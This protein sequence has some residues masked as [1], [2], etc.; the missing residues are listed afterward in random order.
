MSVPHPALAAPNPASP[1]VEELCKLIK[2]GD[3]SKKA[4]EIIEEIKEEGQSIDSICSHS[5]D[6]YTP[7]MRAIYYGRVGIV[8]A[9]ITAGA[10][11]NKFHG[12]FNG[13]KNPLFVAVMNHSGN[14]KITH[15]IIRLLLDKGALTEVKRATGDTPLFDAIKG[16]NLPIVNIL[17]A[18][19]AD[20]NAK[21]N[22]GKTPL[23]L[24][25]ERGRTLIVNAL[26]AAGAKV[27]KIDSGDTPLFIAV[28]NGNLEIVN[29]L[30][31]AGADVN[32][33]A[34]DG[35]TPLFIA[36]QHVNKEIVKALLAAGANVMEPTY[37]GKSVFQIATEGDEE[38]KIPKEI[39]DIIIEHTISKEERTK[40]K[41]NAFTRRKHAVHALQKFHGLIGGRR[42]RHKTF[43]RKR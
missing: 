40:R 19:G 8:D 2:Q 9:L 18:A 10:D 35:A 14:A 6:V 34:N 27:A 36:A 26:L 43:R 4:N 22:K 16:W 29:V 13:G 5:L 15:E 30:I 24:A 39:K 25:A 37:K 7:L 31:A 17:I 41:N 1:A 38:V 3:D 11:V 23:Y 21:D 28:D 20:V 32:A 12:E 42:C 33:K